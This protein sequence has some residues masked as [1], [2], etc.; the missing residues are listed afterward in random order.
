MT[1]QKLLWVLIASHL[2]SN[3][4]LL[5]CQCVGSSHLL[6]TWDESPRSI[7]LKCN[8]TWL[9]SVLCV[10]VCEIVCCESHLHVLFLLVAAPSS[11]AHVQQRFSSPSRCSKTPH[12]GISTHIFHCGLLFMPLLISSTVWG[13]AHCHIT[14]GNNKQTRHNTYFFWGWNIYGV[15]FF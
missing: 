3:F 5:P 4:E 13:R 2:E 10:C 14:F 9:V 15:N 7:V 12:V 1:K 8:S 11:N 6:L